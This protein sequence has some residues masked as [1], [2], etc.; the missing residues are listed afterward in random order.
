MTAAANFLAASNSIYDEC[1]TGITK[2]SKILVSVHSS[3]ADDARTALV[4]ALYAYW[5]RYF[6]LV[7]AEY[8]RAVE[9]DG[10]QFAQATE[11]LRRCRIRREVLSLDQ[12]H[13]LLL[14]GLIDKQGSTVARGTLQA[15][16]GQLQQIDALYGSSLAFP[17]AVDW[18]VTESNVRYEVVEKHCRMFG[19]DPAKLKQCV[20]EGGFDLYPFLKDLVDNRND[21]AHGGSVKPTAANDWNRFREF[22]LSLMNAVQLVLYESLQSDAHRI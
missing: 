2:L 8:L 9:S 14:L 19:I 12:S 17:D 5:E 22:V 13:R 1:Q 20:H 7:F 6:R 15:I 4:P 18:I 21:I 16:V 10:L 11:D 3:I